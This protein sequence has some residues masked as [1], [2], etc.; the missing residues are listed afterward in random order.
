MNLGGLFA[1][2]GVLLWRNCLDLLERILPAFSL[3]FLLLGSNASAQSSWQQTLA[4]A[5]REAKVVVAGPPVAAHREALMK[6]QAA[7]PD[8]RLELTTMSSGDY[9]V[10]VQRE[11]DVH[12]LVGGVHQPHEILA[13]I[14]DVL[15]RPTRRSRK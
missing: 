15:H 6:F 2:P 9:D 7:F 1:G 3:C 14:L 12:D 8:I 11:R 4:A 5:K 13:A 10:R